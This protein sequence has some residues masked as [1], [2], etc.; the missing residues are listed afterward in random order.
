MNIKRLGIGTI[1]GAIVLYLLGWLIWEV[2]FADFFDANSGSAM[3][4]DREAPIMWAVVVGTLCYAIL[5]NY[6]LESGSGSKT[7][8]DG[9]KVGVVV[10]ALIWGTADFILYGFTNLS[11]LTGAVADTVLEGVRGGITGAI[12]ATVLGKVGD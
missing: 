9:L 2:L 1:V 7:L 11:T 3:G 10:G 5:L 4:V 8:V 12:V 6:V